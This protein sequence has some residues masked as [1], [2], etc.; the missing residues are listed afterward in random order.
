VLA[1]DSAAWYLTFNPQTRYYTVQNVATGKF[2]TYNAA[3][4][5]LQQSGTLTLPSHITT[6][7]LP[8]NSNMWFQLLASRTSTWVGC[9]TVT[10]NLKG[11]W[12]MHPDA[13]ATPKCFGASSNGVTINRNFDISN[14]A[15]LQ[16][17][18]LLSEDEVADFDQAIATNGRLNLEQGTTYSI[19][20][21][22]SALTLYSQEN[23]DTVII[24]TYMPTNATIYPAE[25]WTITPMGDDENSYYSII[26]VGTQKTLTLESWTAVSGETAAVT[27][28][29]HTKNITYDA[30]NAYQ[31]LQIKF[32]GN[33]VVNGLITQTFTIA[34]SES[35][36]LDTYERLTHRARMG[37]TKNTTTTIPANQQWIFVPETHSETNVSHTD[38]PNLKVF[39]RNQHLQIENL[40]ANAEIAVYD[41]MGKLH[42]IAKSGKT[43]SEGS[44]SYVLHKG[45]YIVSIRSAQA[46]T[47]KKILVY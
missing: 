17:W 16:R 15:T 4:I 25:C 9:D 42:F 29:N 14:N 11:F 12:I 36:C 28:R 22:G 46:Q 24:A 32:V 13:S 39:C 31:Q 20:P 8:N 7:N 10:M 37:N 23:T 43:V 38:F 2:F 18:L 45:I 33:T 1:N 40:P 34:N 35:Y 30:N 41:I 3:G 47:R 44:F 6:D 19:R 21:L 26:N 27:G 5:G